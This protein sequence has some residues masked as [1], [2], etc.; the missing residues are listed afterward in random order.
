MQALWQQYRERGLVV[1]G[2][3]CNQFGQQEPGGDDAIMAFCALDYGVDFPLSRKIEVNGANADPLW[4]WLQREKR[5]VLGSARIKWNFTKFLV[6]PDGT[7][8]A[9]YAPSTGPEALRADIER[10]L[11]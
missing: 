8:V 1:I 2:F 5:G 3:P 4:Q 7:V 10:V 6:G 9:R 11:G